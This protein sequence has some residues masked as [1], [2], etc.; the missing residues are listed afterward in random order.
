MCD[1]QQFFA[2]ADV[3][4]LTEEEDRSKI[5]GYRVELSINCS[6]CGKAFE[7]VGIPGGYNPSFPTV[8]VGGTTL[9]A[10]L[11]PSNEPVQKVPGKIYN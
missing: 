5:T 8:N 4:R 7:F 2:K 6:I 11:I 1:H 10:P 9:R 3:T